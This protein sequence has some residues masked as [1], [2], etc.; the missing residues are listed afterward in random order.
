MKTAY[1][2]WALSVTA[3]TLLALAICF[4]AGLRSFRPLAALPGATAA[5]TRELP[6]GELVDI[7]TAGLEEL[8]TLP[9][10]GEA[11]AQAILDYRTANGPFRYPEDLIN[12]SGIGEGIL[13]GLLDK[14]TAGGG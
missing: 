11:R 14:I 5:V 13:G 1:P 4:G 9:N 3:L 6:E 7:N 2:K 12:V 8:M 10:I